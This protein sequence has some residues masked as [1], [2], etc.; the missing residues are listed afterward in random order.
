MKSVAVSANRVAFIVDRDGMLV[1]SS[2]PE[3]PFRNEDG[4]QKRVAAR[5]SQFEAGAGG[6]Q[7]WRVSADAGRHRPT[8]I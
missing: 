8:S 3:Q 4:V 5:D 2:T 6:S 1:A 7:W